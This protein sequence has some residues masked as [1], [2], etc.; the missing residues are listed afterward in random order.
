MFISTKNQALE[1]RDTL[2]DRLYCPTTP[3]EER[4]NLIS[5]IRDIEKLIKNPDLLP[6][7]LLS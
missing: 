7:R 4:N 1:T 6:T 2:E 5:L 3:Q